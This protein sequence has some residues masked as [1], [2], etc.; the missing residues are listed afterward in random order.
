MEC[1]RALR[2]PECRYSSSRPLGKDL[3]KTTNLVDQHLETRDRLL[4]EF[5]SWMKDTKGKPPTENSG[6]DP[7]ATAD[8]TFRVWEWAIGILCE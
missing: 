5:Q 8:E 3:S 2:K 1:D 7:H 6:F 4:S